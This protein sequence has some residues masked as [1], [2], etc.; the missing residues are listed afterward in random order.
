[1][2]NKVAI[3]QT[4]KTKDFEFCT[5]D[6]LPALPQYLQQSSNIFLRGILM[7]QIELFYYFNLQLLFFY[8]DQVSDFLYIKVIR[9]KGI[10]KLIFSKLE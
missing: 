8:E 1:M 9:K 10:K 7:F 6:R 5:K 2:Q 3:Y 4:Q